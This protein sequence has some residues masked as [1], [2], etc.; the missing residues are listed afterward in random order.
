MAGEGARQRLF[1]RGPR[2]I[3]RI[4]RASQD[5]LSRAGLH[6]RH[7]MDSRAAGQLCPAG[8]TPVEK[9]EHLGDAC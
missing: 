1:D 3:W 4:D 6:P 9:I 5:I 2:A 8:G 7:P